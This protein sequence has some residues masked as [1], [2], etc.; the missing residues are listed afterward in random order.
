MLMNRIVIALAAL[1][2]ACAAPQESTG[3]AAAPYVALYAMDCG[4]IHLDDAGVFADDGAYDGVAKDLVVPCYLIR[5]SQGD[6][7]WDVG[8]PEALASAGQVNNGPFQLTMPKTLTQQLGEL[9]LTPAD[10]E[11]L[12]VSHSHFDHS[13]TAPCLRPQHGSSIRPS[14]PTRFG[15]KRAPTR[16]SLPPT[17][18]SRMRAPR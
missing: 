1:A 4:R 16:S 3:T 18:R 13:A 2:A 7:I 10:I 12:S 6:L 17:P 11:F 8:L 15:Q 14:A 9:N 5:H